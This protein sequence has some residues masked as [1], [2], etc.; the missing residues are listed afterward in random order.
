VAKLFDY[1]K[2]YDL[3]FTNRK[4]PNE[5]LMAGETDELLNIFA[6]AKKYVPESLLSTLDEFDKVLE[7]EPKLGIPY[8]FGKVTH[9]TKGIRLGESILLTAQEGIGKTELVHAIEYQLLTRTTANVGAIFLEEVPRR[10]LQALAG[11]HL[12][13]AVHLPESG[14]NTDQVR[15][16]LREVVGQDQRLFVYRNFGS[17]DPEILLDLIRYLVAGC[18]CSYILLDH[19]TMVVS[20]D[21]AEDERRKLDYLSTKLERMVKELNYALIVVSHVNDLGQTRGSRY[22]SKIADIRIDA[23]RNISALTEAERRTVHLSISKNRPA[24]RTGVAGSYLFDPLTNSY[25][26]LEDGGHPDSETSIPFVD[27]PSIQAG[28]SVDDTKLTLRN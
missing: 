22:I 26:E 13:A 5:Y 7:E 11:I 18:N 23:Q 14:Y 10:H 4:D 2:I 28:G 17:D 1:G 24:W 3:K 16:A 21:P 25:Q 19:I 15:T 9:L 20:G 12:G 27:S 6:N 8:P